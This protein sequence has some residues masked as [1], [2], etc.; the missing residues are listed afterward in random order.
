M[1]D[2]KLAR[3]LA[4]SNARQL[5]LA[6]KA[7]ALTQKV[8]QLQELVQQTTVAYFQADDDETTTP[9]QLKKLHLACIRACTKYHRAEIS[10]DIALNAAF[11][12]F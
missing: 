2:R 12:T 10:R 8:T 1:E 11:G 9:A 6:E 4:Q 5:K 3:Q 7:V